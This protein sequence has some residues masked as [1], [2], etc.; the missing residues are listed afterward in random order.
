MPEKWI[1][2]GK[3]CI[4]CLP[5]LATSTKK[6][7]QE[8]GWIKFF[9]AQFIMATFVVIPL[10][11]SISYHGGKIVEKVDTMVKTTENLDERITKIEGI[12]FGWEEDNGE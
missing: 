10:L 5:I 9:L 6:N 12:V 2:F 8:M 7:I 4:E 1:E 11:M 3:S